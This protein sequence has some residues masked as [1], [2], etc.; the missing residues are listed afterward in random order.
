MNR[1]FLILVF[2]FSLISCN[3]HKIE[4]PSIDPKV[5]SRLDSLQNTAVFTTKNVINNKMLIT[6][7][8]HDAG[9]TWQF[10]DD[11]STNSSENVMVV[12]FGQIVQRDSSVIKLL[13][14]PLSHFAERKMLNEDWKINPFTETE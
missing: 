10:F 1:I 5:K 7:V 12:G 14:M 3:S 11:Q 4:K 13:D 8:Y 9:G 6:K 2:F